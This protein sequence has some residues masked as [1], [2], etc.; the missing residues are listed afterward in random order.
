MTHFPRCENKGGRLRALSCAFIMLLLLPPACWLLPL[1]LPAAKAR[2]ADTEYAG[3]LDPELIANREDLEQVIL[4]PF[5][6]LAKIKFAAATPPDLVGAHL[7][8]SRLYHPGQDKSVILALLVEAEDETPY[9]YADLNLDNVMSDAER[10]DLTRGEDDNP[11]ILEATLKLPL[12]A[13]E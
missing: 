4:K 9:L 2:A 8:A 5:R 12:A 7:T 6:E 10:F 13:N 3:K 1:L 11:Y